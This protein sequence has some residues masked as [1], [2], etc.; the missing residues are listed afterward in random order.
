M[1]DLKFAVILAF[2]CLVSFSC[3]AQADSNK[4]TRN[5]LVGAIRKIQADSVQ[6]DT[7]ASILPTSTLSDTLKCNSKTTTSVVIYVCNTSKDNDKPYSLTFTKDGIKLEV[8]SEGLVV[9]RS[10]SEYKGTTYKELLSR[11]SMQQLVRVAPY[12]KESKGAKTITFSAYHNED[13]FFTANDNAGVMNV[14]GNFHPLVTYMECLVPDLQKI[15]DES[16][17]ATLDNDRE[18]KKK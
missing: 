9:Y 8:Y 7:T 13:C 10:T 15:I 12:G 2:V 6:I 11:I 18:V 3:Y 4:V 16:E 14:K 5:T 1:K 17:T